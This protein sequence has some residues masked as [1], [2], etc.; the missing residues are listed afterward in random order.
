MLK[1]DFELGKVP[2]QRD[3]LG[4][5]E[6]SFTVKQVNLGR[7]DFAVH[8][9]QQAF[10]LHG[11]QR[12]IGLARIGHA[13]I[14]VG[15]GASRVKLDSHHACVFGAFDFIGRQVVGQ[16]QRHQRFK[17]HAFGHCCLYAR[18]VCQRLR[19]SGHGRAQVG[20]DDGAAKLG[21]SVRHHHA[22]G[23]VVAHMQMP[24]VGAGQGDFLGH[25]VGY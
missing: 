4:V 22:Q 23:G 21:R 17:L 11:F 12:F 7:R 19:C 24:V 13:R 8:Q 16:V 14:A 20:H 15:G 5:D 25:G 6:H 9:Q 3:E 2:A 18:F 10:A 1:H